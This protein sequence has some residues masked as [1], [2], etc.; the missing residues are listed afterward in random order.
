M[1]RYIIIFILISYL[2]DISLQEVSAGLLPGWVYIVGPGVC[3][4]DRTSAIY[5]QLCPTVPIN[6]KAIKVKLVVVPDVYWET[7][8]KKD[9]LQNTFQFI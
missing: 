8:I 4:H 6:R 3:C 1:H 9:Q 7:E 2:W 5:S